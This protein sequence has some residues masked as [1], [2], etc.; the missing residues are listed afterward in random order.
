[1]T[2]KTTFISA[3][4]KWELIVDMW[5]YN[6]SYGVNMEAV[7]EI[8]PSLINYSSFCSFC[9]V[10][11]SPQCHECPLAKE[12]G[13]DCRQIDS[14]Y[15]NWFVAVDNKIDAKDTAEQIRDTVK[16]IYFKKGGSSYE[17]IKELLDRYSSIHAEIMKASYEKYESG[18][19]RKCAP[20][21]LEEKS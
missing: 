2:I 6:N 12:W 18:R 10:W 16:I 7:L 17:S 11:G 19:I 8:L 5:D 13:H 20:A 4:L 1:M 9:D 14:L 21:I 3:L 15:D